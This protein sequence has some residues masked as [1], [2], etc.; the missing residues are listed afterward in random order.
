MP[1]AA[2]WIAATRSSHERFVALLF[3]LDNAG[4][5]AQSYDTDWTIADVASHLGS[6][7]EIFGLFLDTGFAGEPAPGGEVFGPIWDRWNALPPTEQVRAS[8]DANAAFVAR[9]ETLSDA[10]LAAFPLSM[11]GLS[12]RATGPAGHAAGR[13]CRPHLGHRGRARSVGHGRL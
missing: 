3:V 11:F 6:G 1:D 12:L 5:T 10:D 8:I 13:T 4:V 2:V 7:A 9:I